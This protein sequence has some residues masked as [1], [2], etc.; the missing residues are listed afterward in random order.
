MSGLEIESWVG[1]RTFTAARV[2]QNII[3][4][5]VN[6]T[7]EAPAEQVAEAMTAML[8]IQYDARDVR[9]MMGSSESADETAALVTLSDIF[10]GFNG[11]IEDCRS[12]LIDQGKDELWV[13]YAVSFLN[14]RAAYIAECQELIDL[15]AHA[16]QALPDFTV[17]QDLTEV[18]AF[19]N[20]PDQSSVVDQFI[21]K[22]VSH[23]T[24]LPGVVMIPNPDN[25]L[26]SECIV[27]RTVENE[28]G[29]VVTVLTPKG[30]IVLNATPV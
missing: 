25:W 26:A 27:V 28:A 4:N 12:K 1:R 14:Q 6:Q 13:G 17:G 8:G 10:K 30:V 21:D 16:L 2:C 7:Q 19:P 24:I 9:M 20:K 22:L 23:F 11:N 15:Y 5:L 3:T 18:V 29:V